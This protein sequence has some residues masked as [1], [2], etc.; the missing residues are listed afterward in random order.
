MCLM[1]YLIR[2]TKR[3]QQQ[4]RFIISLFLS[5]GDLEM[6]VHDK[7]NY[8]PLDLL[9]HGIQLGAALVYLHDK[10]PWSTFHDKRPWSTSTTSG[11]GLPPRQAHLPQRRPACQR[12]HDSQTSGSVGSCYDQP[13]KFEDLLQNMFR[14]MDLEDIAFYNSIDVP[15]PCLATAIR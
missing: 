3:Q 2:G 8:S 9:M 4:V 5:G 12:S 6:K 14:W 1:S 7:T 13:A 15:T 11:L 10:R